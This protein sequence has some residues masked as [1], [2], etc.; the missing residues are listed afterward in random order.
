MFKEKRTFTVRGV[1]VNLRIMFV[2]LAKQ[3]GK[4]DE[5]LLEESIKEYAIEKPWKKENR[6]AAT[7]FLSN[8]TAANWFVGQV[9]IGLRRAVVGIAKFRGIN[10]GDVI[11]EIILHTLIKYKAFV[12]RDFIQKVI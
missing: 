7:T 2:C 5:K 11:D 12:E 6:K 8:K 4:T 10:T 1:N 3:L 9:D